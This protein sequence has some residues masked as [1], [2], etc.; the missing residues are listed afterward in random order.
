ML[1]EVFLGKNPSN[2]HLNPVVK[3]FIISET[4]VWSSWNSVTPIFSIFAATQIPQ[5]NTEIAASVFSVHLIVRI[6]FELLSG[7]YLLQ[8]TETKKFLVTVS[9]IIF[10][11]I[12]YLGFA[13]TQTV[14]PLYLFAAIAGFAFGIA[15][16]AKNSLFSTHLDKNK[17]SL[18]WGIY[19]ASAFMGMA[20]AVSVGGFIA[21]RYGFPL[22]F[23]MAAILNLFGIIPYILYLHAKKSV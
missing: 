2:F 21:N 8:A 3:A 14:P 19:D 9:G 11:T 7:K 17:E 6:I 23:T 12:A 4:F 16:P 5:G 13:K 15:T 22:L 10:M 18:E 1:R 20:L